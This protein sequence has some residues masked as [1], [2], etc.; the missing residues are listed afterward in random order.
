MR[1]GDDAPDWLPALIAWFDGAENATHTAR[2]QSEHALFD[3][4]IE[5]ARTRAEAEAAQW[6]AKRASERETAL[7]ALLGAMKGAA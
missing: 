3:A 5:A 1:D 4:E 7:R 2:Q 6:R